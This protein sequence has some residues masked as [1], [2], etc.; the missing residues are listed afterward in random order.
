MANIAE[1]YDAGD[2]STPANFERRLGTSLEEIDTSSLA[3]AKYESGGLKI[4]KIAI[5]NTNKRDSKSQNLTVFQR[6][7][8]L[9]THI[10]TQKR[11]CTK[12]I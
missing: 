7:F 12:K 4:R 11:F 1:F 3:H 6:L 5:A 10:H 2:F 9:H 8:L